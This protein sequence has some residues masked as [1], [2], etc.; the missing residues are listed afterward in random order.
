MQGS[1][2]VSLLTMVSLI[3]LRMRALV[4]VYPLAETKASW[5]SFNTSRKTR[6]QLAIITQSDTDIGRYKFAECTVGQEL[7]VL[8]KLNIRSCDKHGH[9]RD[10]VM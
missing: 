5:C 8:E 7:I 9:V 1:L 4:E 2:A 10:T 3:V 6:V